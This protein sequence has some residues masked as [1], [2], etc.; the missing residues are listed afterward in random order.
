MPSPHLRVACQRHLRAADRA[1]RL[2]LPRRLR[3]LEPRYRVVPRALAAIEVEQARAAKGPRAL[4][5]ALRTAGVVND[6]P[7]LLQESGARE[8]ALAP[9]A[10]G[11]SGLKLEL[12]LA[13]V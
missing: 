2:G 1:S 10:S 12:H 4:G 5:I 7:Q 8:L 11:A 3:D 9:W 13:R 6:D